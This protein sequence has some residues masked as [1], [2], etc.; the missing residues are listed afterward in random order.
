MEWMIATLKPIHNRHP[1]Q[2]PYLL[3]LGAHCI[4][5][6]QQVLRMLCVVLIR[7]NLTQKTRY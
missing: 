1:G 2:L 7:G 3:M 5:D 6:Y 4:V